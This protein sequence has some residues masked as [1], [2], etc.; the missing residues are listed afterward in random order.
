M[1]FSP[2]GDSSRYYV[3]TGLLP[4]T[5]SARVTFSASPEALTAG[6]DLMS[7]AFGGADRVPAGDFRFYRTATAEAT[8]G[9]NPGR[10]QARYVTTFQVHTQEGNTNLGG[11]IGTLHRFNSGFVG[12]ATAPLGDVPRF[13]GYTGSLE[14]Y[15]GLPSQN[16]LPRISS[17]SIDID[18]NAVTVS[19]FQFSESPGASSFP[20]KLTGTLDRVAGTVSGTMRDDAG[21]YGGTFRGQLFGPQGV[22][23]AVVFEMTRSSDGAQFVG[24]FV[25]RRP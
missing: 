19:N 20:L 7:A 18:G 16:M 9:Y 12:R 14:Y 22:E 6:Y 3:T 23:I 5:R 24:D 2:A 4:Q 17:S 21:R 25:G 11:R 8:F 15:G 1:T 10:Y 13:L